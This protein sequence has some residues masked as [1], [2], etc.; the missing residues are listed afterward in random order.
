MNA[1]GSGVRELARSASGDQGIGGGFENR[2]WGLEW[3]PNGDRILFALGGDGT[4]S[5]RVVDVDGGTAPRTVADGNGSEYG[6][7]WSPDGTRIAFL[8]RD[9]AGRRD[10][11][12]ATADGGDERVV[13]TDVAQFSPQWSPDGTS[14]AI[15]V[16]ADQPAGEIHVVDLD[17]AAAPVVLRTVVN[18]STASGDAPGADAVGWQRVAP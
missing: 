13:A 11:I 6:A 3:S 12:V 17:A 9:P 10:A 16:A 1:D 5:L 2:T 4:S 7:T 8:R 14:L 18:V 15:V